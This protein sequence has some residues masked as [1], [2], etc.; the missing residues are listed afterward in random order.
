M[1]SSDKPYPLALKSPSGDLVELTDNL[2]DAA[3]FAS[4]ES[5]RKRIILPFHDGA[6]NALHRMLNAVQPGSYIRPH[7]H[8]D[9]PKDEALVLLRGALTFFTFR[10]DGAVDEVKRVAAGASSFGIDVKAGVFHTFI[11]TEPDTV[12]FEVKPGPWSPA[13][14]KDFAT[15]APQ[16]GTT[17]CESYMDRLLMSP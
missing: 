5:P 10:E 13:T 4:R 15:W 2:I 17:E 16:E 9:P 8:L 7:R 1:Q 6:E 14:D 11:A 12:V 3:I